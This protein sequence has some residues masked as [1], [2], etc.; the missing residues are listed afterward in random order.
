LHDDSEDGQF[1]DPPEALRL[2]K[3]IVKQFIS[4][5]DR[6]QQFTNT[7]FVRQ[8]SLQQCNIHGKASSLRPITK[9]VYINNYS[10]LDF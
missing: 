8:N 5:D 1:N 7:Q 9:H 2:H 3:D 4:A 6:E 10:I